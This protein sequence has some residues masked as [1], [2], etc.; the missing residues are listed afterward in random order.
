MCKW[1]WIYFGFYLTRLIHVESLPIPMHNT[2]W[3]NHTMRRNYSSY[4][5]RNQQA[6]SQINSMFRLTVPWK[7][8]ELIMLFVPY[9]YIF[10]DTLPAHPVWG[11]CFKP[12]VSHKTIFG[13]MFL[14]SFLAG[15]IFCYFTLANASRF[16]SSKESSHQERV[17][18]ISNNSFT[19][20]SVPR[21]FYSG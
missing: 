17:I 21:L 20:G 9:L 8:C 14:K 4:S 19:A 5:K 15:S 18:T 10:S 12:S 7:W 11:L 6:T 3:I 2:H 16:S 13:P 1:I